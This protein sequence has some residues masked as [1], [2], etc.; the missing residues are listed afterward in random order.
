MKVYIEGIV[1]K[2]SNVALCLPSRQLGLDLLFLV[3]LW[4]TAL[5][6]NKGYGF[7]LQ[8]NGHEQ[9]AKFSYN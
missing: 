9:N 4:V 8:N 5:L 2:N 3:L 1:L 7:F 6:K